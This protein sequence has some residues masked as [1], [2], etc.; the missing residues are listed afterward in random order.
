MVKKVVAGRRA[1]VESKA[2]RSQ[3]LQDQVAARQQ[4]TRIL[5]FAGGVLVL[6]IVLAAL[7]INSQPVVVKHTA[8]KGEGG[9]QTIDLRDF[10]MEQLQ[11]STR[12]E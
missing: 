4:C 12:N 6:L 11:V 5:P 2:A 3:R 7:F 1:P 9:P 10:S 8:P